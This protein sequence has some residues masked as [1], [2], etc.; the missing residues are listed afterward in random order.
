MKVVGVSQRVDVCPITDETRDALDQRLSTFLLTVGF[1]PVPIPNALGIGYLDGQRNRLAL[2][3]WFASV[4]PTAIV[5]SGGN[6][7]GRCSERDLTE[8]T[9]LDHLS[10]HRTPLLGICRGMQMMAHWAGTEIYR[11][12]GHIGT[13]HKLSGKIEGEANSYHHFSLK[14]CPEDFEVLARSE[15]GEIEAIS[16]KHLPWEGWMWH[17][18]REEEFSNR[19]KQR[20]QSLFVNRLGGKIPEGR[21]E[22]KESRNLNLK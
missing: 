20:I 16:H 18:E 12:Q 4:K 17:P 13:R 2:H 6:D 3:D 11:V 9:L 5:L 15:D 10:E 1:I 21:A 14:N 22:W 7:I 8:K 19:D